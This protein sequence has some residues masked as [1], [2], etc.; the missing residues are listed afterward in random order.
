MKKT[1]TIVVAALAAAIVV[2]GGVGVATAANLASESTP[3]PTVTA[4]PA[5]DVPVA[6]V[7]AADVPAT[8]GP[9]DEPGMPPDGPTRASRRQSRGLLRRRSQA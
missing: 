5:A 8:D 1:T 2:G 9:D 4:A 3:S 6:D 7:P